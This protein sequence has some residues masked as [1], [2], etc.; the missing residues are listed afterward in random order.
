[1]MPSNFIRPSVPKNSSQSTSPC[2][3]SRCWWI[4][5]VEPGGLTMYRKPHGQLNGSLPVPHRGLALVLVRSGPPVQRQVGCDLDAG[6][7][8][9]VLELRYDILVRPRVEK[10][11]CEV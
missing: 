4:R 10:E 7:V 2:P 5:A 11:R 8:Q 1:M 3:M 9:G 6:S